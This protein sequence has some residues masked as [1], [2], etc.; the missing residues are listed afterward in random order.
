MVAT[1]VPP[2]AAA[3]FAKRRAANVALAVP[4]DTHAGVRGRKSC[5]PSY[6]PSQGP[7][8]MVSVPCRTSK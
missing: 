7:G 1:G 8:G 3:K 5:S 4:H 2:L 6:R